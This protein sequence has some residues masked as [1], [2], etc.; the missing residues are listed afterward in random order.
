MSPT[1]RLG[2]NEFIAMIA[3]L[4]AIIALSI[5]AMLPALPQIANTLVADAPN[6]AQ[7]VITSFVFGMGLGTLF[8]GPLSD[9]FGRRRTLLL[10]GVVYVIGALICFLAPSLETLLFAR[11][12]QGIGAAAP[13]IVGLAIVRDLYKGR[14]MA[15]I[16]SVA[17]VIFMLVPAV[18]PLMGAAVI[19]FAGWR[20]IFLCYVIFCG[21]AMAWFWRRQPETLPLD[22]RRPLAIA[23]LFAAMKELTHHR[24][25]VIATLVQS[26]TLGALF[27]SLSS[28]QGVFDVRFDRA[29]S[30]PMWFALIAVASML[31]S[32]VNAK[33]VVS[34]GMRK[35]VFYTYGGFLTITLTLLVLIKLGMM[36]ESLAFGAH[37]LWSI[38]LFSMMGL[39]MGNLTALSMEPVG[40]IAGLAASVMGAVSTVL[41]VLVAVPLGLAFD[42]TAEPLMLG[43]TVLIACCVGLMKLAPRQ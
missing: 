7:L 43:I 20:E 3:T 16:M 11:V 28:M 5:D 38:A 26:L 9:A 31:G 42:G 14:E 35:V 6:R 39:T 34:V 12:I 17:M 18:A 33:I 4:F 25:V 23:T 37:I 13:R 32:V 27:A 30:F 21:L 41:A 19:R 29:D 24:I 2:E 8:V 1:K 15:K 22:Q 40:H 10:G 36:P